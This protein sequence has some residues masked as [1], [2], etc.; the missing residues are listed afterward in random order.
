[1]K[2]REEILERQYIHERIADAAI[3]LYTSSCT[4]ARIDHE[5]LSG[6]ATDLDRTAATLF[7]HSAFDRFD[8]AM[9][10]LNNPDDALTTRTADAALKFLADV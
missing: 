8:G 4:L 7:L 5:L 3:A 1:M 2:H 9:H 6:Q 10:T